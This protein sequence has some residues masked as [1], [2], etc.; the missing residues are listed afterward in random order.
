V[1]PVPL[2]ADAA[3]MTAR[4]IAPVAAAF[5]LLLRFDEFIKRTT[6]CML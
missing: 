2:Q 4:R 3:S 6:S 5:L 1:L